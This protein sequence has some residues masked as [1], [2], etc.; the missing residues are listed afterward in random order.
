MLKVLVAQS[1]INFVWSSDWHL[2]D[3]PPGRRR[4]DYRRAIINKIQAIQ[5]LCNRLSAACLCGGDVF[6]VKN[7]KSEA[8]SHSLVEEAT[9]VLAE[10][11]YNCVFGAIGNHDIQHDRMETLPEQPLGVLIAAGV[12]HNLVAES[13]LFVNKD[14]TISVLVESFGY[15]DE[16]TTLRRLLNC[17]MRPPGVTYRIGIVHAFGRP[18]EAT[19]MFGHRIIGY[20]ELSH[21]D[22]D[23]L[24]W[25]HD[26][27]RKETETVGNITHVNLG[28]L[29]RAAFSYDEVERP[30]SAVILSFTEKGIRMKEKQLVVTPLEA[31]FITADKIVERVVKTEE[32]TEFFSKLDSEVDG[33]ETTDQKEV[34]KQLCP[35]EEQNVL[36]R[37]FDLCEF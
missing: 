17:G 8:N 3:R 31:A 22:F 19:E 35:A 13:V 6:H 15:A 5:E 27:S 25:G 26:H 12:Y 14:Q 32:V 30:V 24:L 29:A 18:G 36:I 34:L 16:E 2:S 33:V 21:L 28:S 9:R 11:P 10:F 4:D 20:D 37:A 23:F 1:D 7:P